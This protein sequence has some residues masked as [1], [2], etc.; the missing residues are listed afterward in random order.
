MNNTIAFIFASASEK[1]P[2]RVLADYDKQIGS[3]D[4]HFLCSKEKEKILKKDVDLD[5]TI[6]D[7]YDVVCPVGAEALKY[8]CGLTGITKYNGVFI[9]KRYIPVIHPK[10]TVFKPQYDDDIK[11]ALSMIEKVKKGVVDSE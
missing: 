10:L 8:V 3:Y 11:K 4:T 1:N 2:A 6:L 9:E 5:L 7:D